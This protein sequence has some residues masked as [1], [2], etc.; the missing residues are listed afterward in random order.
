MCQQE[1][2]DMGVVIDILSLTAQLDNILMSR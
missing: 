2:L 1:M